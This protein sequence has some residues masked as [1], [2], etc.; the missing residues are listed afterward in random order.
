M[1]RAFVI[2]F[3]IWALQLCLNASA[4]I[5]DIADFPLTLLPAV[6]V[7]AAYYQKPSEGLWTSLL[8]GFVID[9]LTGMPIGANG[10]ISVIGFA[11]CFMGG[12]WL[13]RPSHAVLWAF[14]AASSFLYRLLLAPI[15]LVLW[16]R[17]SNMEWWS[18]IWAPPIDGLIG[19]L[20]IYIWNLVFA[21]LKISG[22]S[23]DDGSYKIHP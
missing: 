20:L 1:I 23:K 8:A 10:L 11:L 15:L 14:V 16:S 17:S 2:L 22:N 18:T 13:G 5:W 6:W 21:T 19:L 12:L 7:F 9:G 3:T 4:V